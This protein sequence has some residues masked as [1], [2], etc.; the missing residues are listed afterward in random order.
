M[1]A[2]APK[3]NRPKTS[4]HLSLS[5]VL[6]RLSLLVL[7][8]FVVSRLFSFFPVAAVIVPFTLLV[9]GSLSYCNARVLKYHRF[10]W[11][12][13]ANLLWTGFKYFILVLLVWSWGQEPFN[14]YAVWG[15]AIWLFLGFEGLNFCVFWWY[16]T[17]PTPFKMN[18]LLSL[19]AAV[20]GGCAVIA[21]A[22]SGL[23]NE[24]RRVELRYASYD[25]F[26]AQ[27]VE[28][29]HLD[30]GGSFSARGGIHCKEL[31]VQPFGI[32]TRKTPLKHPSIRYR[33]HCAAL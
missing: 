11:Y 2:T 23:I 20:M 24:P 5:A 17:Q 16:V 28:V 6:T 15:H 3:Q 26:L 12:G 25:P 19:L 21:I 33:K 32:F 30:Y 27:Q 4:T 13:A 18:R 1:T 7:A 9:L 10:Y 8:V 22:V 14:D 31:V 29:F